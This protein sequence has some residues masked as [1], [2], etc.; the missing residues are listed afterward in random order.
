MKHKKP[1]GKLKIKVKSIFNKGIE[2]FYPFS[3]RLQLK[4]KKEEMQFANQNKQTI[5]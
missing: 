1:R 4:S 5:L 2:K 3:K